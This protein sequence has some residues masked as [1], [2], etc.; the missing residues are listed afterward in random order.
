MQAP[1]LRAQAHLRAVRL[2]GPCPSSAQAVNWIEAINDPEYEGSCLLSPAD[3]R[4]EN[5]ALELTQRLGPLCR[6]AGL[7]H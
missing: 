3:D 5:T 1:R 6:P 2:G 7:S 4:T